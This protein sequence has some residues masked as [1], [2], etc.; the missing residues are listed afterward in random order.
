[1]A[2]CDNQDNDEEC[3]QRVSYV[4]SNDK[5]ADRARL[6]WFVPTIYRADCVTA[7]ASVWSIPDQIIHN[8][9]LDS[10]IIRAVWTFHNND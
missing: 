9:A 6:Y 10:F 3:M 1:M 4:T 8:I 5:V 2:A 7:S